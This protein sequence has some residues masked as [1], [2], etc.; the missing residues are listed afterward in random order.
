MKGRRFAIA[1][2]SVTPVIAAAFAIG[3][4]QGFRFNFTDSAPHGL[5]MV[6]SEDTNA[7]KRGALIEVCPPA[8]PI[9]RLMAERGTLS[10][11]DC[12]PSGVMPFL[13]PVSAVQGDIVHLKTGQPATVNGVALPNT[14]SMPAVPAW[15]DGD[16]VV[17]PGEVWL[18]SSYST[19]SFDSRY[20]GSVA[21]SNVRGVAFPVA[22]FGNPADMTRGVTK[23]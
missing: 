19:G 5:W 11:G 15:P 17:K 3:H 16:Y 18:F 1:A 14:M 13:K 21:L 6:R 7:I 23:Q 22:V 12:A 4:L 10:A 20:F 8:L 9:V 2:L